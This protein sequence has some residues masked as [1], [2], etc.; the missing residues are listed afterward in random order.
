MRR[1]FLGILAVVSM[2]GASLG[3]QPVWATDD[4]GGGSSTTTPSASGS[5][6]P[7]ATPSN[8][9]CGGNF[10]GLKP[11]YSG[12]CTSDGDIFNVCEKPEPQC[13][14]DYPN[15][16][17][18]LQTFIW[19]V[20]LNV[21][22]DI[23]LVIGYIAAAMVIY[24]GYLF[25][26]SQGD[27]SRAMRGK[28]TITTAVIGMVIGLGASV[29]VNTA[30]QILNINQGIDSWMAA[31]QNQAEFTVATLNNIFSW[32]YAMAG[33]VAVGF[34]IKS[35]IDYMISSGDLGKTRK[36]T[37]ALIYSVVGLVVVILAAVI[38]GFIISSIGGAM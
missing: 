15:G 25:I 14:Q 32:A 3:V 35:G 24:G 11:W 29:F 9:T 33:L 36:A 10:L 38:T 16:Y 20:V 2:I 22:F 28:K 31:S 7:S 30:I 26:M 27:P 17:R 12:L 8:N 23:T 4:E 37:H 18:R 13:S 21:L 19:R 34:I 6:A 1:K 5:T